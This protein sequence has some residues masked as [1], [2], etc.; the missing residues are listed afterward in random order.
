M[1]EGKDR[2]SENIKFSPQKCKKYHKYIS[3]L[4]IRDDHVDN[5]YNDKFI[6]LYHINYFINY[7]KQIY[8]F[9]FFLLINYTLKDKSEY[10][11]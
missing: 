4:I 8:L 9:L 1:E 3:I 6:S 7:D 10:L 2:T 11:S 5:H